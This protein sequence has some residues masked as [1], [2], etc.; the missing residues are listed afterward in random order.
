M[1]RIQVKERLCK[2]AERRKQKKAERKKT[3]EITGQRNKSRFPQFSL[4]T[5]GHWEEPD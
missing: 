3:K 5:H 2:Y 1:Q 4:P